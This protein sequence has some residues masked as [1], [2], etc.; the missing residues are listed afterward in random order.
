[1]VSVDSSSSWMVIILGAKCPSMCKF[2]ACLSAA[3][4]A[5]KKRKKKRGNLYDNKFGL[6][7]QFL[8][9]NS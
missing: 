5:H 4:V 7:L 2:M 8:L 3:S 1:M 6:S 9:S